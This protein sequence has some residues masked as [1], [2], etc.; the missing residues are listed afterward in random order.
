MRRLTVFVTVA[1]LLALAMVGTAF[2][3]TS[4]NATG[5]TLTYPDDMVACAP[6]FHIY[7]TG[8]PS[9]FSVQYNIFIEVA[10]GQLQQIGSGTAVGNLDI[11][12]A[13]PTLEPGTTQAYGV[14]I[15][16]YNADGV[17]KT[18]LSGQW[19]VTCEEA[20]PQDFQGCTPGY[21]RQK[22]HFDSWVPTG[23]APA[24]SYNAAF[25]VAGSYATLL[26]AVWARGGG[27]GA[28]ARQAVAA[29][30]N[31]AHPD[32]HYAYSVAEILNGVQ[33]AYTTGNFEPFKDQLDFANNAGCPLD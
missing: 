32:V 21:W 4:D 12:F 10:P 14:F 25:G 9:S 27:E 28:L 5:I 26:D 23:Y 22:H 29:L 8:V 31:A 20:P 1:L 19:H 3:G 33:N 6:T 18:K 24:D 13:P 17:L 11:H 7:T 2:A 16:V 30:L 15:A